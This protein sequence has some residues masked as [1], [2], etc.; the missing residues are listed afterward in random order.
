MKKLAFFSIFCL[1]HTLLLS[2][3]LEQTKVIKLFHRDLTYAPKID[4]LF[5]V[6][7]VDEDPFHSNLYSINP[8]FGTVDTI[9]KNQLPQSKI[10]RASDDGRFLYIGTQDDRFIYRYNIQSK[11]IDFKLDMGLDYSISNAPVEYRVIDIA[12]MPGKPKSIAVIREGQGWSVVVYDST[13]LRKMDKNGIF[14]SV[15]TLVFTDSTTLYGY[16]GRNTSYNFAKFKINDSIVKYLSS[17]SGLVKGS[18]KKLKYIGD[19]YVYGGDGSRVDITGSVPLLAGRYDFNLHSSFNDIYT[20]VASHF[21]SDKVH[22]AYNLGDSIKLSIFD[23]ALLNKIEVM[24]VGPSRQDISNI[25]NWGAPDKLVIDTRLEVFILRNCNNVNLG[26]LSIEEGS[27]VTGCAANTVKLTAS[28]TKSLYYWNTGDTSRVITVKSEDPNFI[29]PPQ[30]YWVAP[31]TVDGCIGEKSAIT[32]VSFNPIP[33]SPQIYYD[34]DSDRRFCKGE[35]PIIRIISPLS[36]PDVQYIWSNGIIGNSVTS[37]EGNSYSARVIYKGCSSLPSQPLKPFFS[38]ILAPPAPKLLAS[39]D[40]ILC[41][42]EFVILKAQSSVLNAQFVW[43]DDNSRTD[44]YRVFPRSEPQFVSVRIRDA[45]YCL[46]FWSDTLKFRHLPKPQQPRILVLGKSLSCNI[47]APNY[48]WFLN[49]KPIV[50]A[51]K[52]FY[53]AI[54]TGYYKVQIFNDLLCL[55]DFS[56]SLRVIFTSLSWNQ[57]NS[58]KIFPN[59]VKDVLIINLQENIE[60]IIV[61]DILGKIYLSKNIDEISN[62]VALDLSQLTTGIYFLSTKNKAGVI[63]QFK[64][65]KI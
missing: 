62:N 44:E 38:D 63:H 28:P 49:N 23:K 8:Y 9:L 55:S 24:T 61:T 16:E 10:V 64:I 1:I 42:D 13:H 6:G 50:G 36:S 34:A 41:G 31:M 5:A 19:N 52:R 32:S 14:N 15:N 7:S 46:S 53:E 45:N 21:Y 25:I 56:D 43:Y 18:T 48:Q 4:K 2:Q 20:D 40:S 11:S 35:T 22:F 12:V 47:Q 3:N 51:T 58:I 17:K 27:S 37:K 54:D 65:K 39:G 59:P 26:K 33:T 30:N 29:N 60:S 57:A